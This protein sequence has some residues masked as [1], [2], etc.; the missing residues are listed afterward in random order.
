MRAEQIMTTDVMT[1]HADTT[2]EDVARLLTTRRIGSVPVVDDENRVVGVV[3]DE[4]LFTSE[5]G[6]PFSAVRVPV[7]FEKWAQPDRAAEIYA[8]AR[9]NTAR[10]V[11]SFEFVCVDVNASVG[12]ITQLMVERNLHRVLVTRNERLAGIITRLDLIRM[13]ANS[14]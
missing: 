8:S 1:V 11:V 7:L 3:N 10:D 14:G 5:K 6:I 12:H 9:R 4:E 13:L 2:I